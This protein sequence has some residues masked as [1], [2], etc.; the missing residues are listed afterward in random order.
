MADDG[1]TNV[2]GVPHTFDLLEQAGP[3]RLA[4]P[5]LRFVAQAGGR[6]APDKIERWAERRGLIR[7]D[8]AQVVVVGQAPSADTEWLARNAARAAGGE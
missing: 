2:A 7:P 1:V 6:L 4:G 3:D 8:A 5:H